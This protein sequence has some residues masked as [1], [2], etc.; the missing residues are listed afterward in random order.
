MEKLLPLVLS[1]FFG[2]YLCA[3]QQTQ[4]MD[5]PLPD[6]LETPQGNRITSIDQWEEQQ[7]PR[8]F[9]QVE[10]LMYGHSPETP[11]NLKF[12]V[13]EQ[14]SMALNGTAI[15]KQVAVYLE[16][17]VHLLDLLIYLPSDAKKPIPVFLGLNF[18]GN[19][20]VRKDP[21]IRLSSKWV[22][23]GSAG[24]VENHATECSRGSQSNRWPV[25]LILANGFGVATV[26]AGDLDPDYHDE[27]KNGIHRLYPE[28][29]EKGDNFSTMGAWAWGLSRCMDYFETDSG[30][31]AKQ[32][33]VIGFSRM[34]K[35][36]IWAGAKDERF[37]M[38][39][40]N[41]SGGGG[42]ALSKRM[43]GETVARLNKGNP[44]WFCENFKA[45]NDNEENLP[46]DQHTVLSLIAPR[47]IYIGSAEEDLGADP[48]G[49][50]LGLKYASGVFALYGK[51]TFL[52]QNFPEVNSPI[53]TEVM[54]Y[55]VR[56]GNH[57]ITT[58]DWQQYLDF[59]K[60]YLD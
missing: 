54:G 16:N 53:S 13:F 10:K 4:L 1:L 37:A 58:F 40:S 25:D 51:D 42:A 17:D 18:E 36:A 8:L 19:H 14:D 50:F 27:F 21:A 5:Y 22:W 6:P 48:L 9:A 56:S 23:I 60:H 20:T 7:R 34:G 30:I 39:V 47:G 2:V 15:R 32:I 49:E 29:Q 24:S 43:V 3:A 28:L 12:V 46:F 31:N 55:H 38:V 59:A 35:A 52:K 33:A 45:F 26:Y 41:D 44:H 57:D 11:E